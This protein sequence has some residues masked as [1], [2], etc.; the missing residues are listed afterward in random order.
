MTIASNT[1]LSEGMRQ[2]YASVQA[3]ADSIAQAFDDSAPRWM[4]GESLVDY[5]R[6]LLDQFK[7]HSPA[8][9]TVEKLPRDEATLRIAESQIYTD[10]LHAAQNPVVPP[11]QMVERITSD[12]SGRRITR[13]H[14]DPAAW[15]NQFKLAPQ[16]V[17][18]IGPPR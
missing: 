16:L 18:G 3:K 15:M 11:G 14:G 13:F 7:A 2:D 1:P 5:R 6:R 17:V 9:R 8:W 10:A 12:R 4:N